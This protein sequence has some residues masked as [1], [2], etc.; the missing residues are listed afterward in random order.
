MADPPAAAH[1]ARPRGPGPTRVKICGLTRLEDAVA[2]AEVGA[3]YLGI[4]A[5]RGFGRSVPPGFGALVAGETGRSVVAVTVDEPL[6]AVVAVAGASRAAVLQLH[7][8]EHPDHLRRLRRRGPW[9]LWKAGRVRTLDEARRFVDRYAGVAD[10]LLLDGWHPHLP[11]GTGTRVPWSAVESLG[12]RIPDRV[13]F[14]LAGGLTPES[15]GEALARVAPDTV[16]VSSGVEVAPGRK[17]PARIRAFVQAARR[18]SRP[19]GSPSP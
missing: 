14:V 1:D 8:R 10:G 16:D 13:E 6:D 19:A 4:I 17:D 15:V 9:K 12:E 18:D 5:S 3:D 7:G 2:A 11:G